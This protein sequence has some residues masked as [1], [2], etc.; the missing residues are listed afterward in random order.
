MA[1][2]IGKEITNN[3]M[4]AISH[5]VGPSNDEGSDSGYHRRSVRPL[6]LGIGFDPEISGDGR[7][8][9]QGRDQRGLMGQL[10]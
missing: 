6:S 1:R 7:K 4:H 3:T 5:A 10:R 9:H 2:Y 8:K